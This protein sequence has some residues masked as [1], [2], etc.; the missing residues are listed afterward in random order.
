MFKWFRKPAVPDP[1]MPG[2][3]FDPAGRAS[4]QAQLP[5]IRKRRWVTWRN[6]SR[7]AGL[8]L[9]LVVLAI[10]WLA[11]TAPLSKSLE[12]PVPPSITLLSA[13]GTPIARSGARIEDPVDAAAL[14]EHVVNAFLAIEDRRFRSHWGVDPRGILR[15]VIHNSFSDGRSQGAS[16]ITQQLAKN[17]FLNSDRTFTRKAREVLIAFWLEAWLTKDDILSRYLSNVYFG[18][19]VYGLRAAARHYF[20]RSPE[21]LTTAQAAMLAGLVKA[22]SRLAPTSNLAGARE[23][24]SVVVGAMVDAGFLTQAEGDAVQPARLRV[25]RSDTLPTGTYFSD[26]VLPEARDRAGGVENG[27]EIKTTLETRIQRAAEG[28][29]RSARLTKAQVA[30]VAMRPDGRVVAMVGG[31]D[32]RANQFNRATAANRQPGSTFKLFVYLAALRSGMRPDDRVE[33]TPLTIAGWSPKNDGGRYR[34]SM[35]LEGAFAWSSNVAAARLTNEVGPRAVIRAARDLGVTTPIPAE[36]TIALGTPSV[37]L[38]E[39]TAAYAAIAAGEYPVKPRGLAETGEAGWLDRL[40]GG[41]RSIGSR[42]LEDMRQLLRA[43]VDKGSGSAARLPV[44]VYG[45]T[46]TT[47]DN[48]DGWFIG[49]A[50]GLIVGVWLGND[51]NSPNPGLSGGG[52]PAR[53]W[54]DVMRRAVDL[55]EDEPELVNETDGF[56]LGNEVDAIEDE[57]GMPGPGEPVFDAQLGDGTS[58]VIDRDGGVDI[59]R[60]EDRRQ[61]QRREAPFQLDLR[62]PRAPPPRG[63]PEPEGE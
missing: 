10:G 43:V 57:L 33:D 55:P 16:T 53:L 56:D 8:G 52:L 1:I 30:I 45:K 26:W 39:L 21:R 40:T 31:K 3:E 51:D 25:E 46:G 62:G 35:S 42:E 20:S 63:E 4:P 54:A 28:A 36:A 17:A 47:Q 44:P 22:P 2:A 7:A 32:Y 37:S 9:F 49:Y 48:R 34:G 27:V 58:V 59:V 41:R 14:P 23:R 50:E 5:A 6:L 61:Q 15:A 24:Q 12:P 18:D 60:P 38:L 11:F 29:V 13:E 19:N